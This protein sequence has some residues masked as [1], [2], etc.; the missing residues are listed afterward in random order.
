[1]G[2]SLFDLVYADPPYG[3]ASYDALLLAID[4]G[5]K[6]SP[7]ALVAIE[8]RR[9]EEPFTA[10]PERLRFVRRAEDGEVWISMFATADRGPQTTDDSSD[11][12]PE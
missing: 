11:H 9:R 1:M 12:K 10:A 6:L 3:F 4:A 5:V 2:D 7:D 8:H